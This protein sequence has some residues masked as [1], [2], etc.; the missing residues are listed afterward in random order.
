M[1]DASIVDPF[2]CLREPR[3]DKKRRNHEM[4]VEIRLVFFFVCLVQ[5]RVNP[6]FPRELY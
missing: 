6:E 5:C 2:A 1:S 4:H 3:P